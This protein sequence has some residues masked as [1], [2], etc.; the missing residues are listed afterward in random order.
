MVML[1]VVLNVQA[2]EE[3]IT[4][5]YEDKHIQLRLFPRTTEQ[6][7]AFFE[8]RGF[9]AAMRAELE[10]YCFITAVIKNKSNTVIWLDLNK[11][12]FT[13][14]LFSPLKK[15]QRIPRS[16][17]PPLWEKMKIPM[18]SQSTFRW[19]LLPEQLDFQPDESEGGNIIL[20]KPKTPFTLT[21]R[22]VVDETGP[23]AR[24]LDAQQIVARIDG[25][26]CV[27]TSGAEKP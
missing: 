4:P 23:D 24:Q 2:G 25:L 10:S 6:M 16:Q 26:S 8:A 3:V 5:T 1:M 9:P 12:Q 20:K 22:F 17:W 14:A 15:I 11:W 21:A 27:D 18:A 13:S 19:T 7:A